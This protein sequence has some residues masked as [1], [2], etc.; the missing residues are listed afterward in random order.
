MKTCWLRR[1]IVVTASLAAAIVLVGCATTSGH[2]HGNTGAGK[3]LA[4]QSEVATASVSEKHKEKPKKERRKM[5][6]EERR[7]LVEQYK[8]DMND[9]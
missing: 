1:Q 7:K 9:L 4:I 2:T 8:H 6:P 5:T 3:S